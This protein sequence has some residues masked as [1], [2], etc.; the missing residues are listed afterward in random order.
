MDFVRWL[1]VEPEWATPA[2][3]AEDPMEFLGIGEAMAACGR[4]EATV[5]RALRAGA[6]AGAHR[7]ED[8]S[9]R[10]PRSGLVAIG[11]KAAPR[12]AVGRPYQR[13]ILW[14]HA[15]ILEWGR[16]NGWDILQFERDVNALTPD[17]SVARKSGDARLRRPVTVGE[18]ARLASHLHVVHQL[19]MWL[20][21]ILGLR[22][23]EAFGLHVGDVVDFGDLGLALVRRQ[24][25]R[26]FLTRTRDGVRTT[27][28][29][30]SLKRAASYRAVVIPPTL[31]ALF[32]V[33]VAAFH[34]DPN[35][36]LVDLE[37]RLIPWIGKEGAGQ[38]A[39]RQALEPALRHEGL[40]LDAAGFE[41]VSHD[42][43]KS[44]ATVLAWNDELDELAKRRFLG[45]KA[46]DDVFLRVYTLDHPTLAPLVKI[47]LAVEEDITAHAATLMVPTDH[48]VPWRTENPLRNR[49]LHVDS[50]L[51]E[52]GWQ[53]EPGG[54]NPWCDTV[55][56][57]AELDVAER[58]ARRWMREQVVPS[59]NDTDE[60]GNL[61]RRARLADVEKVREQL[62]GRILLRDLADELGVGYYATWRALRRLKLVE[63]GGKP[64]P[65]L[66]VLSIEQAHAVRSE[67]ERLRALS[68]RSMRVTAAATRLGVVFSTAQRFIRTGQLVA[69]DER[70]ASGA[71]Y[72]TKESVEALVAART[73]PRR[74]EAA[75]DIIEA[76]L[77]TQITGL[78]RRHLSEL[79]M[80][81]V[82]VRVDVHRRFHITR[83]SV[84]AWV[85]R[86][87]SDALARLAHGE[88]VICPTHEV[89]RRS[90]LP[91]HGGLDANAA[92]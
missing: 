41:L 60:F 39:F 29:K 1:A 52:A 23:S 8:G 33:V 56:V 26:A 92:N 72:V 34:T 6:I 17:E 32:R 5:R 67:F 64:P 54:D 89:A 87:G 83:G 20:M 79:C 37:A 15:K 86:L 27:Y 35:T 62:A 43:R 38:S 81:G 44:V 74:R 58:T 48:R 90:E 3:E 42:F 28:T 14:A 61:R 36:G 80:G 24:G 2:A 75:G 18:V 78:S 11:G 76:S 4:S 51:A 65:R 22:I 55:R 30:N 49:A 31:M 7:G 45:H 69:D 68:N 66:F 19:S 50:V 25:G 9:W 12:E 73:S 77:V 57:A 13:S 63:A 88:P 10:I 47:A 21:R 70:D 91:E 82:L 71:Q 16:L 84:T 59:T 85:E 46:G 40:D 53:V